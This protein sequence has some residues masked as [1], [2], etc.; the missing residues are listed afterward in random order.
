MESFY[1]I[2]S[3]I[4]NV[5]FPSSVATSLYDYGDTV[6]TAYGGTVSMITKLQPIAET[7]LPV[8]LL[9]LALRWSAALLQEVLS[10]SFDLETI[11]RSLIKLVIGAAILT[12]VLPLFSGMVDF[13]VQLLNDLKNDVIVAEISSPFSTEIADL[14]EAL[15]KHA[16]VDLILPS[17][18]LIL[19][20]LIGKFG[21]VFV[22]FFL[23]FY[24]F[25][26]TFKVAQMFVF[27]P[28]GFSDIYQG[29]INS[30]G[31][32]Y[33]RKFLAILMEPIIVYISV[34]CYVMLI[35]DAS[36]MIDTGAFALW[37]SIALTLALIACIR[38]AHKVSE[39]LFC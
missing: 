1:S 14:T 33:A 10:K 16:D 31:V 24:G 39:A 8:G 37:I 27:A 2:L 30:G 7:L 9:L 21:G 3:T 32:R 25:A 15:G 17:F 36:F 18:L 13:S 11:I 38:K 35:E 28:I 6:A 22:E 12:N 5:L 19:V 20:D 23:Y 34:A 26:R 4:V 29:G